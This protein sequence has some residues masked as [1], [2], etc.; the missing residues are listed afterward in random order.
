MRLQYIAPSQSKRGVFGSGFAL[1]P[2]TVTITDVSSSNTEGWTVTVTSVFG[3]L[4]LDVISITL[5]PNSRVFTVSVSTTSEAPMTLYR[6]FS[7]AG[8]S[9]TGLYEG[10]P[11]QM[12]D[13]DSYITRYTRRRKNGGK[14]VI[15]EDNGKSTTF[16]S[17]QVRVDTRAQRS[18]Y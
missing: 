3:S 2:P 8:S 5:F 16:F 7:F 11:T 4:A 9:V 10:G 17:D 12:K 6:S 13:G 1:P 18:T 15:D 14:K